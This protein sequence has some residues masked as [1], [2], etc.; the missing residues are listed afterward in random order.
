M[1]DI[2][3]SLIVIALTGILTAVLFMTIAK[4]K[5]EKDLEIREYCQSRGYLFSRSDKPLQKEISIKGP[6]F[7]LT[8]TMASGYHDAQTGSDSWN[9]VSVWRTETSDADRL[10]FLLGSVSASLDWE[11]LPA[12]IKDAAMQTLLSEGG[13]GYSPELASIVK[14][15]ANRAFLLFQKTQGSTGTALERMLPFLDK[16]PKEARIVIDSKT[17][18]VSVTCSNLYIRSLDDVRILMDLGHACAGWPAV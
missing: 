14:T 18:G 6:A 1:P 5:A 10:A 11:R 13:E 16:C 7:L 9:R 12:T 3:L 4:R 17:S 8:S 15:P 2:V